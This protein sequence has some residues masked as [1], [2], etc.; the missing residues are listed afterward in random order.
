M[1]HFLTV[2]PAVNS[3]ILGNTLFKGDNWGTLTQ[4]IAIS[5]IKNYRNI[6]SMETFLLGNS[7]NIEAEN[8]KVMGLHLYYD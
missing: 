7:H 5:E 3:I 1:P 6:R 8:R 2:L 4:V